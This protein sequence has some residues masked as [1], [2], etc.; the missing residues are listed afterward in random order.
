MPHT[1]NNLE[2]P[3]EFQIVD[4]PALVDMKVCGKKH[5]RRARKR[6][7]RILKWLDYELKEVLKW[8][9]EEP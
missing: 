8:K 1:I 2:F 6:D 3:I 7:L 9:G 4:V 5:F